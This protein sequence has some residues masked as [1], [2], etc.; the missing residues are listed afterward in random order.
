MCVLFKVGMYGGK[1]CPLHEGHYSVICRALSECD[2]VVTVLFINGEEE[3]AFR[4]RWFTEPAFRYYQLCKARDRY[5]REHGFADIPPMDILIVDSSR[6]MR[7]GKEDWYMEADWI[8]G[9]CG[10]IDAVYSSEPD[11]GP[12]FRGAYPSA[13]H[14]LVDPERK[15]V[16][17]S[18]TELRAEGDYSQELLKWLI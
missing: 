3:M 18:A 17:I 11:Y 2:K 14:V 12:F 9:Q 1:F 10:L 15:N 8:K 6:F 7:D 5:R 16:P 13:T 4:R